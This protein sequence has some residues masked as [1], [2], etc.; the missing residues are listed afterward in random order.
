MNRRRLLLWVGVAIFA[1]AFGHVGC[2]ENVREPR[3][4][5]PGQASVKILTYNVNYGLAGDDATLQ[6]I[7]EPDADVVLLQETTSAWESAVRPRAT[8]YSHVQFREGPGAGGMGVLS[9]YPLRE[10][11]WIEP[12]EGGWFPAWRMVVQSPIGDLQVL[13]VHLRP[14]LSERGSV[15]SGYFTTPPVREAEIA[16]YFQALDPSLPTLIAGDFNEGRQGLAL[17]HLQRRGF[18]SRLSEFEKDADTWRWQTSVGTVESELDHVVT[19]DR[20]DV[21]DVRVLSRGNSDH[22]PLV[23]IVTKAAS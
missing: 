11:E 22:L 10:Q 5:A 13:S 19:D 6:A 15:V 16:K 4:P 20:L 2:A 1:A 7:L 9:K 12:P 18:R 21:L 14:Q 3:T 23:A 8:A 17:A